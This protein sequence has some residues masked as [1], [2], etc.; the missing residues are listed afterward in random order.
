MNYTEAQTIER[1]SWF[2]DRVRNATSVYTNYLLNTAVEDEN[3]DA[4][5]QAATRIVNSIDSVVQ[6]LVFT[7]SGDAEVQAAGP[8]IPD[9]QL[10]QI[11]EKTINK[12]YPITPPVQFTVMPGQVNLQPRR[13]N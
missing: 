5:I 4:K 8:A 1:N 6:T 11:V 12:F 9:A 10:Q 2:R 3:Y 13:T 7:L